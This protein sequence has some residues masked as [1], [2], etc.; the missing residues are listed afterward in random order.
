[1][2]K[3][4]PKELTMM[5]NAIASISSTQ[6]YLER[7]TD[8]LAGLAASADSL[9]R[10]YKLTKTTDDTDGADEEAEDIDNHI[11]AIRCARLNL[12]EMYDIMLNLIANLKTYK[13]I[14]DYE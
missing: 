8:I 10:A 13:E 14:V 1:V 5:D 7:A 12:S 2:I 3:L 11:R 9:K 6:P 4:T